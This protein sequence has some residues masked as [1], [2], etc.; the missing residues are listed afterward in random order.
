MAAS[1]SQP[2]RQRQHH[3]Q[4]APHRPSLE[5]HSDPQILLLHR[6]PSTAHRQSLRH[7]ARSRRAA[8]FVTAI[9]IIIVSATPLV[10]QNLQ[11]HRCRAAPAREM[12]AA[13][14]EWTSHC[15]NRPTLHDAGCSGDNTKKN[16]T[17]RHMEIV[18]PW[19]Q[20][21]L[22]NASLGISLVAR[23]RSLLQWLCANTPGRHARTRP[24][25]PAF[26]LFGHI[27]DYLL[28]K[29]MDTE[30]DTCLLNPEFEDRHHASVDRSAAHTQ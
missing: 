20:S 17:R 11:N 10:R 25:Y 19:R 7:C 30:I 14:G 6:R 1:A 28:W 23:E 9:I 16:Q 12:H 21:G 26:G 27:L 4:R 29:Q 22:E 2:S 3:R 8:V 13:R 5:T 24:G 15:Y 18:V